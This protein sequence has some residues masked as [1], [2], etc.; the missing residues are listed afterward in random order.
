MHTIP[1]VLQRLRE[2]TQPLHNH[3][4]STDLFSR[5]LRDDVTHAQVEA[6]M[7]IFRTWIRHLSGASITADLV[8]THPL[9]EALR[10][11]RDCL[12]MGNEDASTGTDPYLAD[13]TL[14]MTEVH[15]WDGV[16]YVVEGSAMG[17]MRIAKHLRATLDPM[18][19]AIRY[20]ETHGKGVMAHWQGV[21]RYLDAQL[22]TEEEQT[23]ALEG[24]TYAFQSLLDCVK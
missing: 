13:T 2:H 6:T 24:A 12:G 11:R 21:I 15:F 3:I 23:L 7:A 18:P 17:G 1:A 14:R 5:L 20:F 10:L 19:D 16:L 9:H 8:P 4:D 22:S